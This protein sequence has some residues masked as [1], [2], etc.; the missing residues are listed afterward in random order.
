MFRFRL[1]LALSIGISLIAMRPALPEEDD[2]RREERAPHGQILWDKYAIPH[3]YGATTQDVLYGYGFA[4]MENHAETILRKVATARGRLAEYFGAGAGNANIASDTQIRTYDIP[5]RA[6]VWLEEGGDE[7]RERLS[8]FCDGLNGYA[9]AHGATIDPSLAAVLP[10]RPTDILG[11]MQ[12]TIHFQFLPGNWDLQNVVAAWAQGKTIAFSGAP[13]SAGENGSNGWALAPQK[14]ANGHAILMGNPHLPWGVNQPVPNLDIYQWF[15]AQLVIGDP[16]SPRLSASGVSFTGA[17]FIG[18][19]FSDEIGWTHTNNTIKNADLYDIALSGPG[20]YV[21]DGEKRSLSQR[22]DAI[23]VRQADGSFVTLPVAVVNSV[24]GPIIASR[25]DG[26]VLALRVAGLDAPAITSQYW[27]MIRSH[28]LREFAQANSSLQMP[29][30]NVIFADRQGEIMYLFGGAQPVRRGGTFA[31]YLGV[32][33]GNVSSTLW[34]Q[35]LPWRALPKTINP[36]SGFVQNSNDPPWTSTFPN[37]IFPTAF[38]AWISPVE[39]TLRPQQG[40]SYLLSKPK[41][42]FADVVAGKES[43]KLFLAP[44]ILPD[45]I[46]AAKASGDP[47]ALQAAA[48]LTAWDQTADAASKGGPLF[49]RWYEIYLSDPNTPRSLAFGASYPAFATEWSLQR[50]LTTPIGL[51]KPAGAVPALIQAAKELQAAFGAINIDWG[52]MDKVVLVSHNGPFTQTTPIAVAPQ[53]GAPD[54]FGP[55]RVINSFSQAPLDIA[56]GGDSYVQVV[57]FDPNG[58]ARAQAVLTYGNAS[59]PG[60]SHIADQ[61][62]VFEAKTLRPVLRTRAEVLAGAVATENY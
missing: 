20:T 5:N 16:D 7:Q 52:T 3:I 51:A 61:L 8:V 30:F 55:M 54:V 25:A 21:F 11:I 36:A 59:R 58:G 48:A 28:N 56:Y 1:T 6:A 39:M 18:I 17:P 50:A 23:K 14:S 53:S 31:D 57:D 49:R 37:T 60:S 32:L 2:G 47:V 35:I 24:Q 42:S 15:E 41:L 33:N 45:L 38:P 44:R 29:F 10:V 4:Q 27:G 13:K 26:H 43:T 12:N 9:K 46:A 62:A 40:A 34:T 19:G 22:Q